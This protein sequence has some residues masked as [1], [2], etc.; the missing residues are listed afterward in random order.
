VCIFTWPSSGRSP[1]LRGASTEWRSCSST[2]TISSGSTTR[3]GTLPGDRLLLRFAERLQGCLRS[4]DTVAR[5]A[6]ADGSTVARLGGDEFTILL[7]HIESRGDAVRVAERILEALAT[8][9]ELNGHEVVVDS[10]IG[11]AIFPD[12]SDEP[13]SLLM[14]A[15]AAMY[16]AKARG[17]AGFQIYR[18]D[19]NEKNLERLTLEGELR[20]AIERQQ[21]R[22]LFQPQLDLHTDM[23]VAAEA[24]LRWHHPERGCLLPAR[25]IPLAEEAGLMASIGEWV[26]RASCRQ[27]RTW[28]ERDL[29][30]IRV[31]VNISRRQLWRPDFVDRVAQILAETGLPARLLELEI[32]ESIAMS[33]PGAIMDTLFRLRA[34]GVQLTLDDF[35]TGYS[36]LNHLKAFPLDRL[37]IDGSFIR[38]VVRNAED[39]EI[40]HA[41][42]ALA[43]RLDFAVVA[44]SVE[45]DEQLALLCFHHCDQA[46]G[47]LLSPPLP[48]EEIT[49]WLEARES[50]D[51]RQAR[52]A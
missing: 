18:E 13:Q 29:K 51:E 27:A 30:E 47:F 44:E 4:S 19:L 32:E 21:L 17:R 36:S 33:D 15:D 35:G 20:K 38:D 23:V 16:E 2:S 6:A 49:A 28:L 26:L 12:D 45:T 31:A 24:L 50:L 37:K 48:A 7:S 1:A 25:F 14:H 34:M 3:S 5:L 10:S 8:P 22:L 40:V 11:I 46:Q 9:F 52:P 42:I 39:A 41:I 43:H